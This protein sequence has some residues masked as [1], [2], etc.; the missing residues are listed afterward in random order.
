M[1]NYK[2]FI[3]SGLVF[4]GS[5]SMIV[6]P[7][8]E[9]EVGILENHLNFFVSLQAGAI[10]IFQGDRIIH[11]YFVEEGIVKVNKKEVIIFTGASL[12]LNR[13]S[14]NIAE[15]R[16]KQAQETLSYDPD[17]EKKLKEYNISKTLLES[18]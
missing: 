2:N 17:N 11:K 5:A 4:E 3:P 7:G 12:D 14:R 13:I 15:E 18:I 6:V 1:L 16:L 8:V 9:G 10:K